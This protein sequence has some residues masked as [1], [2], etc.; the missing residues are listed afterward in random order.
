M[1]SISSTTSTTSSA[2]DTSSSF[3]LVTGQESTLGRDDF[4]KLLVAQLQ[5]QDPLNPQE[6]YEYVAQLAQ[7][8]NLEQTMAINDNLDTLLLQS[9]GQSNAQVVGM[10]GSQATVRGSIVSIDGS[11]IGTPLSYTLSEK[12]ETTTVTITDSS[13][14][15]IR[16]LEGGAQGAGLVTV[17]WDGKNSTGT[18]QP[19][20]SYT[21]SVSATDSDGET[22]SVSQE[23]TGLV[24]GVSFDQGY[25]VL[26]L[27]SGVSAPVSDLLRV[28]SPTSATQASK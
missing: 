20:G 26:E 9:R 18:V 22:V 2:T 21:V 14:N 8:S 4:L 13:G 24:V 15:T 7:F 23:T 27:D 11:G 6:N 1:T 10:V 25:P 16:T 19:K 28:G 3:G 17:Q 5:N 12:A